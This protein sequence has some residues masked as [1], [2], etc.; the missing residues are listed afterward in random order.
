MILGYAEFDGLIFI[1]IPSFL[2]G[3][4]PPLFFENQA[5]FLRLAAF[6]A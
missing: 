6:D 1:K 5:K 3:V 4:S 2:W